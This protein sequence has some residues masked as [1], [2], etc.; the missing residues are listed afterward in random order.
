MNSV[1][2][3]VLE[4]NNADSS[5]EGILIWENKDKVSLQEPWKYVEAAR[6]YKWWNVL[7]LLIL[8]GLGEKRGNWVPEIAGTK[9][10][11]L[12]GQANNGDVAITRESEKQQG[13]DTSAPIPPT[14]WF[15]VMPPVGLI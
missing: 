11:G 7:S 6:D 3:R 9:E 15:L 12:P 8:K 2:A 10:E 13:G 4:G 1:S 14:L 5:N